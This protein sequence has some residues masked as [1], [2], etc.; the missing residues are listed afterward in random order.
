MD[1]F[2][3]VAKI[4]LDTSEYDS[5]LSKASKDFKGFSSNLKSMSSGLKDL[6]SPAVKGFQAVEGVGQQAGNVMKK[7]MQVFAAAS[8]AVAGFGGSAVNAGM[9][10][11]AAMSQVAAV[12]GATGSSF[13]ALRNKAIEMGA[14]TQFSASEAAEAMNYMAMAGWKDQDMLSGISGIMDLAAA[15]GEDLATTSDIVT[16]ALTAFGLK[17]SDSGH[18]ADILASASSNANTN[19][20]MMGETFKYVAPLAGAMGYSAED[21]A[22]AIGL[23]ANSGIKASQAGTSLRSIMTRLAKPTKESGSAMDAL[24][25]SITNSDGSMKSLNT[26]IGDLRTAFSGLSEE[27]KAT[28]AAMLGGQEAMSGLLAIVNAAPEDVEKLTG[29]LED[30][31]G[32]SEK[33][34]ATMM[35]NLAGDVK[36]FKSALESLQIT[37]SDALNPMLRQFAQF[38]TN[39]M[40]KLTM[41]FQNGGV[42]GF[43]T[44]LSTIVTNGI[45]LLSKEASKFAEVSLKF[46]ESLATGILNARDQIVKSA[47]T[48][49][50]T[51]ID[52]VDAYISGHAHQMISFGLKM[53]ETIFE[54]FSRAGSVISKHIG[55]FIPLIAEAFLS[56]HEALFTVGIEILGA[57]GKGLVENKD[58]LQSMASE[59]I[60]NMARYLRDNASDIIDGG[61]ALLEALTGAIVDNLP[62]IMETGA[63]IIGKLVEGITDSVPAFAGAIG[64]LLPHIG[65]IISKIG[66][67]KG[68]VSKVIGFI[69]GGEGIPKI[70]GIGRSLMSGIKGLFSLVTSHPIIAVIT[71]IV[72][73]LMW[74]W[75][76][77][78]DFRNAVKGIWDAIVGF[79]KNA[80]K[81][82]QNAWEGIVDFFQGVWDGIVNVFQNVGQWFSDVFSGAWEAVKNAWTSVTEFFQGIWDAITGVFSG[83]AE[84]FGNLFG[85]AWGK[86]QE[87]TSTAWDGIT[88]FLGDVWDGIKTT[89]GNVFDK[90]TT[91][92]SKAWEHVKEASE[93]VWD[94][95]TTFLG[96]TWEGIKTTAGN[97]F[98]NVKNGIGK[99]WEHVEEASHTIWDGLSGW[100][101][102]KW[103]EIDGKNKE[104]FENIRV[105]IGNT[106]FDSEMLTKKT[107]GELLQ[108]TMNTWRSMEQISEEKFKGIYNQ[109]HKN[110]EAADE[111]SKKTWSGIETVLNGTWA[112]LEATSEI[113]FDAMKTNV[114][115]AW[116]EANTATNTEWS[117]LVDTVGNKAFE[118]LTA[119][120]DNFGQMKGTVT[121]KLREARAA[122]KGVDFSSVGSAI[123]DGMRAGVN[124]RAKELANSVVNAAFM[125]LNAAK[126][127]LGINSPSKVFRDIIGVGIGEGMAV[128]VDKS[129]SMVIKSIYNMSDSIQHAFDSSFNMPAMDFSPVSLGA[130][131]A[132]PTRNNSYGGEFTKA[133]DTIVNIYSPKAVDAIEADRL[134]RKSAQQMAMGF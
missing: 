95:I 33:M 111:D 72:G 2:D 32:A 119:V 106:W 81:A 82:I 64:L 42:N 8:T 120:G 47:Q 34:A 89:A 49:I 101:G 51:L 1:V 122:A 22:L 71:A 62:L 56:Y 60:Q 5:K 85:G 115:T 93:T 36:L 12:S 91:S 44:E 4:S 11:D 80:G 54:G 102:D 59:T 92:I 117:T 52:G 31:N 20:G 69:G 75:N 74:L 132:T 45:L 13:D 46:V 41:G 125:A 27:E 28:Y 3:L 124:E 105:R 126:K 96:D 100:L 98:D 83:I 87:V 127:N 112:G 21:T 29:A 67:I 116:K 10:F 84:F 79:F 108:Y 40:E 53:V 88:T 103:G 86:V 134:F 24:G 78:E 63:Q 19:V 128:G 77:N 25:I 107:W 76:T 114:E 129:Q 99:A 37:V 16:D 113:R 15:S 104:S 9:S 18:F 26:I 61:I 58:K 73:G 94:G 123:V 118:A 23:M 43:F 50:S 110:W 35:D 7:G 97:I 68:I 48:I 109:V 70:M 131:N 17:A 14:K 55:Q 30:C 38:G 57:I 121:D 6:F 65:N 90:V 39:A 66:D 130:F 133:G